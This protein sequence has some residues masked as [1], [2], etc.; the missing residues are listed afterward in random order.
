MNSY[1]LYS[2]DFINFYHHDILRIYITMWYPVLICKNFYLQHLIPLYSF[3]GD[4]EG[5]KLLPIK[6]DIC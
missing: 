5:T 6:N 3:Y 4:S 2:T 1:A